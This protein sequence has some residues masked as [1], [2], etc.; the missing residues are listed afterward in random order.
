[1]WGKNKPSSKKERPRR[2]KREVSYPFPNARSKKKGLLMRP[3]CDD[4]ESPPLADAAW[5]VHPST[6]WRK[7]RKKGQLCVTAK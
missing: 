2:P 6:N 3:P 1:M 4:T 7:R 5:S